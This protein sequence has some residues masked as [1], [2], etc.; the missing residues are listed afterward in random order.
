MQL[1]ETI[2]VGSGGAASIEFT[3]IP[4]DG[5][6][7]MLK[8]SARSDR[9]L[10]LDTMTLRFNSDSGSNYNWL[11]L[12]GNGSSPGSGS[13]TGTTNIEFNIAADTA[14]S[15]TYGSWSAHISNYTSTTNK[16]VSRDEVTENNATSAI[17]AIYAASYTTSSPITSI[18]L[19]AGVGDYMEFTTASLYKIT[20]D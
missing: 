9:A 17:Q 19:G 12:S 7:L 1:I 16:S 11:R 5:V 4:Q 15:G 3:S 20:A 2:E 18:Q 6:D 10:W 13:S 8:V 14:T